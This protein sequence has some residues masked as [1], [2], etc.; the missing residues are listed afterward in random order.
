M[1]ILDGVLGFVGLAP[2]LVYAIPELAMPDDRSVVGGSGAGLG[3]Q[4]R[5]REGD[6]AGGEKRTS[7]KGGHGGMTEGG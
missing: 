3:D 1:A 4:S 5:G 2:E 7:G 6:G